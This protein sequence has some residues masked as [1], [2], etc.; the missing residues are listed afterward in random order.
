[1][2]LGLLLSKK[3]MART[4]V[5]YMLKTYIETI[6]GRMVSLLAFRFSQ[7]LGLIFDRRGI[8]FS[9]SPGRG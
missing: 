9:C 5:N 6:S 1:M 3:L 2:L 7:H 8:L 4:D